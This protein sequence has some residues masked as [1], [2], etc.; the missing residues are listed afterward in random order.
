[1]RRLLLVAT[2]RR[3]VRC[4]FCSQAI[5]AWLPEQA[6][7]A[8][9]IAYPHN[10]TGRV[11]IKPDREMKIELLGWCRMVEST[12]VEE[13]AWPTTRRVVADVLRKHAHLVG[14][15]LFNDKRRLGDP[16]AREING[17]EELGEHAAQTP[18]VV[19]FP[20]PWELQVRLGTTP[21]DFLCSGREGN[22]KYFGTLTR[23]T[24]KE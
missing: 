18:A 3:Q 13:L 2:T 11:V 23:A 8:E 15:L 17:A 5:E 9:R 20:R 1:M 10:I 24:C 21:G 19:Q 14:Q 7:H 4:R 12:G 22:T 16:L 6:V